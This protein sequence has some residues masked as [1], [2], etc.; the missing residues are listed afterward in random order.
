LAGGSVSV[1]GSVPS[2]ATQ[3]HQSSVVQGCLG[4][5]GAGRQERQ[6]HVDC[7]IGAYLIDVTGAYVSNANWQPGYPGCSTASCCTAS[8]VLLQVDQL[9][10]LWAL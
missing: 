5:A 2:M 4:T 7:D 3:S 1:G 9:G 6:G 10:T 8:K